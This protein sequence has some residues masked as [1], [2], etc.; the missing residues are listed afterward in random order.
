M[1]LISAFWILPMSLFW[2]ALWS[3]G[4]AGLIYGCL[5]CMCASLLVLYLPGR[6][7][8]PR[9]CELS[10]RFYELLGIRLYKRWMLNGDYMNRFIR[11]SAPNYRV[12]ARASMQWFEAQTRLGERCHLIGFLMTVTAITCAVVVGLY[13]LAAFLFISNI[14]INLYP[15]MLQRYTRGCIYK[16]VENRIRNIK[17]DKWCS[18]SA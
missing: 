8:E 12:V 5:S 17:G 6:C 10:G 4:T 11:R 7:C 18:E 15:I 2:L 3:N 16:L 14:I 13:W 1:I 9:S